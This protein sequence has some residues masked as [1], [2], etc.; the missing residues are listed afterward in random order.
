MREKLVSPSPFALLSIGPF[1]SRLTGVGD[2]FRGFFDRLGR[3]G[4]QSQWADIT[5]EKLTVEQALVHDAG[6]VIVST[7]KELKNNGQIPRK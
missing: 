4:D 5:E 6:Q 3:G 2:A 1:R 7:Y